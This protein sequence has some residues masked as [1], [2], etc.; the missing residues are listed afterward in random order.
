VDGDL[1]VNGG[2]AWHGVVVVTGSLKYTGGG[3]K[4]VTGGMLAGENADADV[5]VGGSASIVYCSSAVNSQTVKLPLRI[6][7]WRDS[8]QK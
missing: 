7:S 8:N 1:D 6:L 2:F 3:K 5:D 4:Q